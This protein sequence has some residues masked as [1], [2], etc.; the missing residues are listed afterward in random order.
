[1]LYLFVV[2]E[3]HGGSLAFPV[4]PHG[5]PIS[6]EIK[7]SDTKTTVA[8]RD[9]QVHVNIDITLKLNA[10]EIK[11][12]LNISKMEQRDDLED[13]TAQVI[14][15]RVS[16]YFRYV[17]TDVGFDIFGL[18]RKVYQQDAAL[19]AAMIDDWDAYFQAATVEVSVKA[20]ILTAGVLKQY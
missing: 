8:V 6:L 11:S 19:W 9:G 1:M 13:L 16:D 5:L 18:G 15:A 20:D 14:E 7:N 4:Q 10:I 17:Q 3:V 2:G 12:Q